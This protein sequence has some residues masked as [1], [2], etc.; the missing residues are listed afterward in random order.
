MGMKLMCWRYFWGAAFA[1]TS[2]APVFAHGQNG[3]AWDGSQSGVLKVI[4]IDTTSSFFDFVY[5]DALG[6]LVLGTSGY[7]TDEVG[8]LHI[9]GL[10]A[11][12]LRHELI[13]PQPALEIAGLSVSPNGLWLV[14]TFWGASPRLWNLKTGAEDFRFVDRGW[15]EAKA[16]VWSLDGSR[17]AWDVTT[18]AGNEV[19]ILDFKTTT[20]IDAYPGGSENWFDA[21]EA[22]FRILQAGAEGPSSGGINLLIS[23]EGLS[24]QTLEIDH[25]SIWDAHWNHSGDAVTVTGDDDT[26]SLIDLRQ[27]ENPAAR[28]LGSWVSFT[29]WSPNG[30]YLS[31]VS[32]PILTVTR[33]QDLSVQGTCVGPDPEIWW[34][35]WSPGGQYVSLEAG[36]GVTTICD[37]QN[38]QET[39]RFVGQDQTEVW[40]EWSPKGQE[41]LLYRD[42]PRRI[43]VLQSANP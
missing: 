10:P 16:A 26:I 31:L 20:L 43:E 30:D 15:Q 29:R 22:G 18:D 39:A 13:A 6:A 40:L 41:V 24:P 33:W 34:S 38:S 42:L 25:S 32:G 14:A 7:S 21:T 19:Q 9:Y 28:H 1:L 37:W 36:N 3:P 17:L 4:P 35:S 23:G 11:G 8:S 5:S 27:P 2:L 12:E